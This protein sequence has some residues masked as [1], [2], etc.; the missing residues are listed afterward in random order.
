MSDR[1]PSHRLGDGDRPTHR[2]Q[3]SAGSDDSLLAGRS[4]GETDRVTHVQQEWDHR[5]VYVPPAL[6]EALE[7]VR[8]DVADEITAAFGGQ[9]AV[10]R[11]FYPVMIHLGLARI[12]ELSPQE[13]ADHVE[14]I[15]GVAADELKK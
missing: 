12:A 6:D 2:G 14:A 4:H 15:P 3:G 1:A 9:L 13:F 5:N 8:A 10:T 7:S 11:H